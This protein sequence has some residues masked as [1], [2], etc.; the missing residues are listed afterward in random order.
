[1]LVF[2]VKKETLIKS[3]PPMPVGTVSNGQIKVAPGKWRPRSKSGII[4]NLSDLE[5]SIEKHINAENSFKDALSKIAK[6]L[7]QGGADI[8]KQFGKKYKIKNNKEAKEHFKDLYQKR[9][10]RLNTI[11]GEGIN[12][13]KKDPSLR[14][15]FIQENQPFL[16]SELKKVWTK[17]TS[18]DDALQDAN[19]NFMQAIDKYEVKD[20][21][22]K[23]FLNYIRKTVI[24]GVLNDYKKKIDKVAK[25]YS[26]D[27]NEDGNIHDA[28]GVEAPNSDIEEI[29]FK[30]NIALLRE[31]IE[32]ERA[33][34]ILDRLAEGYNIANTAKFLKVDFKTVKKD[35]EDKIQPHA[36]QYLQKSKNYLFAEFLEYIN[37]L[38]R[39]EGAR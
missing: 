1:M 30:Q 10:E 33:K 28:L 34:K 26:I 11:S 14:N 5:N 23:G 6:D 32:T 20:G 29:E 39:T 16:K 36:K 12:K 35:I 9:N 27:L 15:K 37:D 25:E 17:I 8:R 38:L 19:I 13:L 7:N 3:R 22:G 21:S 18:F 4:K 24:G 2:K 31:R